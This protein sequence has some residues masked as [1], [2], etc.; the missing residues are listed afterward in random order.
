[1]FHHLT[2]GFQPQ[3]RNISLFFLRDTLHKT[4]INV[5]EAITCWACFYLF[6][7]VTIFNRSSLS[8]TVRWWESRWFFRVGKILFTI[9]F[10][11]GLSIRANWM[12]P[13]Q[14]VSRLSRYFNL[15]KFF[16]DFIVFF[17][18]LWWRK[19]MV[20]SDPVLRQWWLRSGH[21]PGSVAA[22]APTLIPCCLLSRA[23]QRPP[24]WLP[25]LPLHRPPVPACPEPD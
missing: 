24:S 1:M 4:L 8:L 19:T 16:R 10:K 18:F 3:S 17:S 9:D 6:V 11:K 21:A 15:H 25:G 12:N 2:C 13:E 14:A 22:Q 5:A 20:I 23:E 7:I